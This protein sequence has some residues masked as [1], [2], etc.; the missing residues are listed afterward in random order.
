MS[1][2]ALGHLGD[3]VLGLGDH[4]GHVGRAH[5]GDLAL[6]QVALLPGVRSRSTQARL[7]LLRAA[8]AQ[9]RWTFSIRADGGD[10]VDRHDQRLAGEAAAEEVVD[11]VLRDRVEPVI[12]G[13]QLVLLPESSGELALLVLVEVGL[14][15]D[16]HQVVAEGRVRDLQL[17]DPVLVVERDRGVVGGRGREVV[18]RD[19]VAEHLAGALLARDQRRAGEAQEARRSAARCAC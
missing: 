10:L 1:M 9:K 6:E 11:D 17:R 7:V 3:L 5:E 12:A 19:V 18:D 2:P 14:L 15:H 13:D 8:A 16:R 4:D